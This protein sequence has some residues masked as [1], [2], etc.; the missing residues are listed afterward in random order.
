MAS[1]ADPLTAMA[2]AEAT[3]AA[4]RFDVR[5]PGPFATYRPRFWRAANNSGMSVLAPRLRFRGSAAA[6]R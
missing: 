1:A 2:I 4:P 6:D 3:M 5:T